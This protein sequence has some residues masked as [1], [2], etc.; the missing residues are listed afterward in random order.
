MHGIL[1]MCVCA[2]SIQW[3]LILCD[4]MDYSPPGSPE[5][6]ILQARILEWAAMPSSRGSFPDPGIEPEVLTLPALADSFFTAS[7]TWEA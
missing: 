7:A 4:P 6:C 2:K 5:H 3:F 1:G